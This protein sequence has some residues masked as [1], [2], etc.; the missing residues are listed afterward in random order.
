[1]LALEGWHAIAGDLFLY[2]GDPRASEEYELAALNPVL[3]RR[4]TA[5]WLNAEPSRFEHPIVKPYLESL[6]YT[7]EWRREICIRAVD[8][9]SRI[10]VELNCDKY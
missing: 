6:G 2:L 7:D 3:G 10:G 8:Y 9:A 5:S 1:M 4:M